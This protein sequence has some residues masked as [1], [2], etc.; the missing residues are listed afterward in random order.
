MIDRLVDLINS[1]NTGFL[2]SEESEE[3][4]TY[5]VKILAHMPSGEVLELFIYD[6]VADGVFIRFEKDD[7]VKRIEFVDVSTAYKVVGITEKA[8]LSYNNK[9]FLWDMVEGSF[10]AEDCERLRE[11]LDKFEERQ[12]C[13]VL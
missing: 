4:G 6:Y 13:K 5:C 3:K 11:A 10:V 2:T 12:T 1:A 9:W 8:T 7:R